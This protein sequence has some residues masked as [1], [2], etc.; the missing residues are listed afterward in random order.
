VIGQPFEA[1][2][3]MLQPVPLGPIVSR[4]LTN[5]KGVYLHGGDFARAI[6]TIERL[7]QLNPH[8]AQQRRDLGAT[9]VQAGEPGRAIDHL[10]P[11]WQPSPTPP[12]PKGCAKC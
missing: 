9:L 3:E 11:T 10:A 1:R 12:M 5:L 4:M 6:R 7:L 8:D 2:P